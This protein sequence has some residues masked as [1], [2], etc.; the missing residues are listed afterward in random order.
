VLTEGLDGQTLNSPKTLD[1]GDCGWAIR[2]KINQRYDFETHNLESPQ[3][4]AVK[5][6]VQYEYK[7]PS[8]T[9][10]VCEI[11]ETSLEY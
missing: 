1:A 10:T 11:A 8:L 2:G 3:C 6:D 4:W 9:N 7:H 5:S